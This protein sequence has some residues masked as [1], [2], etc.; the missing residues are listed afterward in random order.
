MRGESL[1]IRGVE[2][3]GESGVGI[4]IE[5]SS[6]IEFWRKDGIGESVGAR[7]GDEEIEVGGLF[8]GRHEVGR[9]RASGRKREEE[10]VFWGG[11]CPGFFNAF[12]FYFN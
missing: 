8:G 9:D 10:F 12:D 2:I 7:I 11:V 4:E 3:G 6:G 5:S 1:V